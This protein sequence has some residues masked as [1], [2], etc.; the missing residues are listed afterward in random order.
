MRIEKTIKVKVVI[1]DWCHKEITD[2]THH[3]LKDDEGEKQFHSPYVI[4]EMNNGTSTS[5]TCVDDYEKSKEV[6]KK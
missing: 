1:C 4:K 6:K 5:Y 3:I 2:Y